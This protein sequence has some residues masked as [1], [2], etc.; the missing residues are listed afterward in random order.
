MVL[1][2]LLLLAPFAHASELKT[3]QTPR[4]A[5]ILVTTSLPR[6][7]PSV[8]APLLL[9]APDQS[10]GEKELNETLTGTFVERGWVVVSLEYAYCVMDPLHPA[11]SAGLTSESEDF[12]TAYRYATNLPR[13]DHK[14]IFFSG[15]S[16]G[17]RVAFRAFEGRPA[18]AGLGILSP[19]CVP[20]AVDDHYPNFTDETRPMAFLFGSHDDTCPSGVLFRRLR[21]TNGNV[22]PMEFSGDHDLNVHYADGKI[23][24]S[25]SKIV[26]Q[27]VAIFLQKY[28]R[29][30]FAGKR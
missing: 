9:F 28:L 1:L 24:V 4:G 27:E 20:P 26:H 23:D 17:A 11:P 18:A 3:L 6:G 13:V 19:V 21:V 7:N 5:K 29:R 16:F 10:C 2:T 25:N 8:V 22:M 14:K 30:Q 12:E 15:K